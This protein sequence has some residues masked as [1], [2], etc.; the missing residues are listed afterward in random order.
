MKTTKVKIV[1]LGNRITGEKNG[2]KY[3]FANVAFAYPSKQYDGMAVGTCTIGG[4]EMDE[5]KLHPGV[6]VECFLFWKRI[7]EYEKVPYI[8]GIVRRV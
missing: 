2:Y 8:G 5:F 3:D 6:E 4:D 7:N 1:G